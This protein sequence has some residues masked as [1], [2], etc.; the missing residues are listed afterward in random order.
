MISKR[1]RFYGRP[2]AGPFD[3]ALPSRLRLALYPLQGT[4]GGAERHA[5][6]RTRR[7]EGGRRAPLREEDV[8]RFGTTANPTI[9]F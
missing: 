3:F 1:R 9:Q 4:R 6:R 7:G 5:L 8:P 2:R